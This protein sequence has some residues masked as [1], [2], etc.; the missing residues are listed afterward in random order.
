[1]PDNKNGLLSKN[2]FLP[3]FDMNITRPTLLD[4]FY[5]SAPQ[6]QENAWAARQRETEL[7]LKEAYEQARLN[8]MNTDRIMLAKFDFEALKREWEKNPEVDQDLIRFPELTR[9]SAERHKTSPDKSKAYKILGEL[10]HL[11]FTEKAAD[12]SYSDKVYYMPWHWSVDF[13]LAQEALAD[14]KN[15]LFNTAAIATFDGKLKEY[16]KNVKNEAPFDFTTLPPAQWNQASYQ[17]R[18]VLPSDTDL[19]YAIYPQTIPLGRFTINA[20]P[21]GYVQR[22]GE[23]RS[24][25]CL[26]DVYLFVNDSFDFEGDQRLGIW[27]FMPRACL[28]M[29][30]AP[31]IS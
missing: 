11:W 22:L 16:V 19:F 24:R 20:L 1:M 28:A 12:G 29:I 31:G 3:L 15:N 26:T 14:L 21:K 27:N 4:N 30:C 25:I 18:S 8:S 2:A 7:G 5:S 13:S 6:T 23:R 10:F 17:A 9:K